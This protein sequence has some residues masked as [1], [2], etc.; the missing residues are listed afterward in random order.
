MGLRLVVVG[1]GE[2]GEDLPHEFGER[3]VLVGR[4]SGADVRL[5]DPTVSARHCLL[6]PEGPGW[7]VE[8]LGA[9]NPTRVNGKPLTPGRLR[10]LRAG[11]ELGVGRYRITVWPA[12]PVAEATGAEQTAALARRM[13]RAA[14]ARGTGAQ[15]EPRLVVLNGPEAGRSVVVPMAPSRLVV[16]RGEGCDL[17]IVDADAS[18]EHAEL[19]RDLDG[20]CVRDLGSKNGTRVN[21]QL[22]S[23]RRLRH[24]DELTLGRTQLLFEDPEERELA[25]VE[26]EPDAPIDCPSQAS[27]GLEG[28]GASPAA[29]TSSDVDPLESAVVRDPPVRASDGPSSEP[30]PQPRT[31]EARTERAATDAATH[32][33]RARDPAVRG[34]K[35]SSIELVVYAIA[36]IVLAVSIAGLVWLF[37]GE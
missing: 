14:L 19:V 37:G 18:R 16:G 32:A 8:D 25:R 27:T 36:A 29:R 20:V 33:G 11:D 28:A 15:P 35:G 21:D 34:S 5:P 4:S 13:L 17:R 7:F 22:V 10:P 24:G 31:D 6:R 1:A 30:V 23:E 26:S 3:R 2:A 12:T 9:T